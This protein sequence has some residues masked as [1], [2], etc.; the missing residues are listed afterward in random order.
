MN[1]SV[2]IPS[3]GQVKYV[4]QAISS[5]IS[6]THPCEVI[7]VDDGST[8]GSLARALFFDRY[9]HFKLIQQPNKG[10][11]SA[12]NTGIMNTNSDYLFFLDADDLMMRD[13]IEKIAAKIE[14]TDADVIAPSI[15][16]FSEVTGDEQDTI[17]MANP[18][19]DDFKEGNRLPYCCAIKRDALL[20]V[21]GYSP[22]MD[23]LGGYEDLWMW[24]ALMLRG[25]KIATIQEP[26]VMYRIKEKSMY[27]D[28]RQNHEALWKQIIKDFPEAAPHYRAI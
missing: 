11:A 3:Y 23:T 13:C 25:K 20:E 24:Y 14:E 4:T 9:P 27:K 1:L 2:I 8:D 26:L 17:I 7:V 10:L 22:K 15:R 18:T 6:Q 21:G 12:R 19:F 5:A 16:C 28:A